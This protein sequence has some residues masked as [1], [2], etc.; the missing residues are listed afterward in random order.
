M[1]PKMGQTDII[2]LPLR[3]AKD[4]C[5]YIA[6]LPKLHNLKLGEREGKSD[7]PQMMDI[8]Q[9]LPSTLQKCQSLKNK[10]RQRN[11][12]RLKQTK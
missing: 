7:Q 6:F 9:K 5:R 11:C 12:C 2:G 3:Y 10:E 8:L 1:S 4:T